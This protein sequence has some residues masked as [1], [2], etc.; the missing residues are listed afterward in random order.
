MAWEKKHGEI[1][2]FPNKK[3]KD[4]HPDWRGT[5]ILEG[6]SYDIALWNKTSKGGMDYM[7]GM[8]GEETKQKES[9]GG[10]GSNSSQP[11]QQPPQ[12]QQQFASYSDLDDE[13]PF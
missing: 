4:S 8:M 2:I 11:R 9:S 5:I 7:S 1:A 10:W 13:I 12:Q 6:K 3:G